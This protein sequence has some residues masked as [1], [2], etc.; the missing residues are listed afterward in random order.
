LKVRFEAD[1][2]NA[3]IFITLSAPGAA[4]AYETGPGSPVFNRLWT[5]LGAP[6]VNVPG[7]K[8]SDQRPLGV[9]VAGPIG[10]DA[11]VLNV[12]TWL[13]DVLMDDG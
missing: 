12:T 2:G 1:L 9:Q 10:Q 7:L 6:C 3:P 13:A 11:K 5:L 8:T 4:P